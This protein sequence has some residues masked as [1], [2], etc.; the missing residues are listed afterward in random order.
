MSS[1]EHILRSLIRI[2]AILLAGIL[3]FI[4]GSMIGYGA[5]GGG[6]PF[7]VLLPGVWRHILEFVH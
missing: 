5:M 2:V 3:L 6:N 7:K 1:S 4:V